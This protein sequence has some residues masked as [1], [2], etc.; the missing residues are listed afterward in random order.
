MSILTRDELLNAIKNGRIELSPKLSEEDIG[1]ASIDLTL[2][3][4]V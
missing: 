2:G 4:E 1:P 3:S